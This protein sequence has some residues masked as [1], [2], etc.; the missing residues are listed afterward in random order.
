MPSR[1]IA[2]AWSRDNVTDGTFRLTFAPCYK[3]TVV[4]GPENKSNREILDEDKKE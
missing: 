2:S 4:G 1:L 3:D